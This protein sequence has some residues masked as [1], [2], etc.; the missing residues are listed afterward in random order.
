MPSVGSKSSTYQGHFP[1]KDATS[2]PQQNAIRSEITSCITNSKANVCPFTIRLAWHASGTYD[3]DDKTPQAGG[4]DG[5]TMRFE[6]EISDGANAG[7]NEMMNVLKPVKAKYPSLSYADL[8]TL[9]GVHAIKLMGGP[10]VPF[11]FGRSDDDDGSNCPVN[12]RLPDASQG[13]AHLRDVFYRMGFNDQDIVALSG[14]HTVGSCHE[15]RSGF[16]GP[17]TSCPTKFDNEYFVNLIN[18]KWTERKWDGPLQ[19]TDITGK[20]IMLPSD[21]ALI[22]DSKFKKY[23]TMYA[24]DEKKFFKHFAAAFGKLI[25]LGCPAHVQPDSVPAEVKKEP[26][27]DTDF[28]EM[29]MHGNLIRMK[30][31]EGTPN[32]NSKEE[33]TDRTPIHK[34]SYFGHDHVVSYLLECGADV[35]VVDV[36]GDTPLHDAAKLGH[37]ACVKLLLEAGADKNAINNKKETPLELAK[38]ADSSEV[39]ELLTV[40][41]KRKKFMGLF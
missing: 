22:K 36:E 17:W 29:A 37:S 33:F 25:A 11:K 4:S 39:V 19:Y 2:T 20:L 7:L 34:A 6:P 9:A 38:A 16:D 27:N 23:V 10:E 40:P 24:K 12:G 21:L 35:N 28:R 14:G 5:A 13:A 41:P 8:W 3:K 32:P 26:S 18:L 30:E 1:N 15:R 31:I